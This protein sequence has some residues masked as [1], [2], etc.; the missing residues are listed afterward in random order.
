[1]PCPYWE[2]IEFARKIEAKGTKIV[3]FVSQPELASRPAAYPNESGIWF[4][5]TKHISLS[6]F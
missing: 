5:R 2:V 6:C 3:S 1:M 4:E